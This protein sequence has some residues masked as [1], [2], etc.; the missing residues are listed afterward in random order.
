MVYRKVQL[1]LEQEHKVVSQT[2]AHFGLLSFISSIVYAGHPQEG[3]PSLF[4]EHY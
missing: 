4:S 2:G 3:R 1:S